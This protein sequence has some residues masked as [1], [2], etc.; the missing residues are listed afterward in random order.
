MKLNLLKVSAAMEAAGMNQKSL[1]AAAG[2]SE[3]KASRLLNG[4]TENVDMAM[5]EDLKKALGP[6][7]NL[8]AFLDIE[9]AAQSAAERELLRK[10]READE[11]AKTLAEMALKP[12]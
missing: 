10:W 4:I 1:A 5:L 9:D 11:H 7:F 8:A 2:W 6:H 12:R 3:A